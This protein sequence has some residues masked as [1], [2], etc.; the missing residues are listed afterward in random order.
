MS[1]TFDPYKI[2]NRDVSKA[3]D[4]LVTN[5]TALQEMKSYWSKL[6][7]FAG[8]PKRSDVDPSAMGT[9]LEDS[10]I[11]ERVAP[12]VARVRVAGQNITKL[13]GVEP[14]GLPITSFFLPKARSAISGHIEMAFNGPNIV[15]LS[16]ESPKGHGQ[17]KL[18]GKM[19]LL[20]LRDDEGSIAR[21][22]GVFVMSGR[23]GVGARRFELALKQPPRIDPVIR[24][25]AIQG[26]NTD[27]FRRNLSA[28]VKLSEAKNIPALRLVVSN[29]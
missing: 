22:I 17:P 21:V 24:L 1:F 15:E 3:D 11:L 6:P 7:R 4:F 10:F 26:G 16:L 12:G 25:S 2:A 5:P 18:D 23:R 14:R 13:I 29:P 9:L 19:L 28:Q 8:V 20:P 27:R